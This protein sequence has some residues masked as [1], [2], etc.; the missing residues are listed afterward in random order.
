MNLLLRIILLFKIIILTK[1]L[2]IRSFICK[3]YHRDNKLGIPQYNNY[4]I[5]LMN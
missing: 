2:I 3:L 4:K 5:L 1:L